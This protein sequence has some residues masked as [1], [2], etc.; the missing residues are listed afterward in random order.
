M[1]KMF[2]LWFNGQNIDF[3]VTIFFNVKYFENGARRSD[4]RDNV[5]FTVQL[6]VAI[7]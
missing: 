5:R 3:K 4:T 6:P 1:L 2:W 7:D